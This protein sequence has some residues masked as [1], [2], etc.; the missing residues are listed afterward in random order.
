MLNFVYSLHECMVTVT[1]DDASYQLLKGAKI[2]RR[3]SFS[4]VVKRHFGQRPRL[5]E[6]AGAW[7]NVRDDE[8]AAMRQETTDAFEDRDA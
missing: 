1:L 6:S 8:V 7:Y 4:D 5:A 3:E 2:S